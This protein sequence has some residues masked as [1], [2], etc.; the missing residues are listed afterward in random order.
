MNIWGK[1][2]D[3]F[4]SC[5]TGNKPF[6]FLFTFLLQNM[7]HTDTFPGSILGIEYRFYRNDTAFAIDEPVPISYEH[8]GGSKNPLTC[9]NYVSL[10]WFS[11]K[12]QTLINLLP[13]I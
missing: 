13:I 7:E 11:Y 6:Y 5:S 1:K 8:H 12:I 2:I 4:R 10:K 3:G 9:E